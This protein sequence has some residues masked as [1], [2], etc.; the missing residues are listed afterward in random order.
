MSHDYLK[1]LH[2]ACNTKKNISDEEIIET[3]KT[4]WIGGKPTYSTKGT[5]ALKTGLN[6]NI[7]INEKDILEVDKNKDMFFIKVRLGSKIIYRLEIIGEVRPDD[8]CNCKDEKPEVI[9]QQRGNSAPG[10]TL[11]CSYVWECASW[12]DKNGNLQDFCIPKPVCW[13]IN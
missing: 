3:G 7:V 10:N 13:Y 12:I 2:S 9:P 11:K 6:E 1:E 4:I 8:N 5:I